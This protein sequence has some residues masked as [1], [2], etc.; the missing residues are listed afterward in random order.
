[1]EIR[2][3]AENV[4]SSTGEIAQRIE[5]IQHGINGLVIASE[6]GAKRIHEGALLATQTLSGLENMVAGAKSTND[7]ADQISHSTRQQK[8]AMDQVLLALKEIDKGIQQSSVS[9]KQTSTITND[10]TGSSEQLKK[11]VDEFKIN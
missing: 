3:L 6:K 4:M 10:L 2:R 11:L 5:K 8:I 1:V 9:I 7:A